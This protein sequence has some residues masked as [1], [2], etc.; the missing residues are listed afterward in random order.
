MKTLQF[1]IIL[2]VLLL[3]HSIQAQSKRKL[4][5]KLKSQPARINKQKSKFQ[6]KIIDGGVV[7]GKAESLVKPKYPAAAR[8]VNVRGLVSV[9]VLIDEEGN[10]IEAKAVSGHPLLK[11]NSVAAALQSKFAPVKMSGSP[12]KVSGIITYNYLSDVFNWLEI[13]YAAESVRFVRMLPAGFETEKQ[14]Y[15][16]YKS[17]DDTD[18]TL[19]IQNIRASIENKLID[20]RK[21][22]WLFQTG[23]LLSNLQNDCCRNENLE[24]NAVDLKMLILDFPEN[25]SPA[26]FGKSPSDCRCFRKPAIRYL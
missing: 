25:V 16:Q 9:S 3:T 2:S 24:K 1:T 11:A 13:G 19:I 15:E 21:D 23:M 26:L 20:K 22:F 5:Q 12:V 10:L 4:S 17:A 18:Q 7:N 14:L 6:G 8:L